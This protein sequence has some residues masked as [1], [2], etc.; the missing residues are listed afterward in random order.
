MAD[1]KVVGQEAAVRLLKGAIARHRLCHAYLF[2]GPPGCGKTTLAR[3]LA[4]A[5]NCESTD[6]PCQS[7]GICKRIERGEDFDVR[8]IGPDEGGASVQIEQ[9]R[10]FEHQASLTGIGAGYKIGIVPHA[11][12][13]TEEAANAFLKTLEEPPPRTVIVLATPS[14]DAIAATV[15][16][17]CVTIQLSPVTRRDIADLLREAGELGQEDGELILDYADG[18]AGWAIEMA[19]DTGKLQ[20]LIEAVAGMEAMLAG[21]AIARLDWVEEAA[22]DRAA[23]LE[24]LDTLGRYHGVR[25]RSILREA[26][27]K[28]RRSDPSWRGFGPWARNLERI[29]AAQD[30]L[31]ANTM[32]RATLEAMVLDLEMLP[33]IT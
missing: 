10:E 30:A 23:A 26:A 24:L 4:K 5:L 8:E 16:S 15:V 28:G 29:R 19:Q 20:N 31:A 18:R 7:C 1:W 32:V 27:E 13:L 9:V 12:L 25:A 3:A 33:G 11:E 22:P 17:R 14:R 6:P 2:V 21:D